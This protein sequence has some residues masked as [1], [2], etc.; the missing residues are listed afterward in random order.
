[1]KPVLVLYAT[2]EG[3]TKCIAEY[4]TGKIQSL[5]LPARLL[6]V[7][8]LPNGV[9][10]VDYSAVVLAASVHVGK[11]E[12]EIVR[13]VRRH[14]A[15]LN[16]MRTAFLSVSLSQAGAQDTQATSES[17]AK[18]AADVKS[19]IDTFLA[20]TGWKPT[21]V[22]PVAG[23]LMYSKYNVLVRF[24]MK[25]IARRTGASTDISCDHVF[26]RWRDLDH[27]LLK[28]LAKETAR[29]DW[30]TEPVRTAHSCS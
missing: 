10:L 18:A 2:R 6:E 3:H 12:P 1:M 23:A 20:D 17:R 24:I 13:F 19:M 5:S 28:L 14:R 9:S 25:R 27:L 4:L 16:Q 26:T 15:D 7:T 22:Q 11:H 29:P 8:Q 21:L 30:V